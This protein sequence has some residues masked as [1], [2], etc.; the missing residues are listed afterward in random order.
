MVDIVFIH[1]LNSKIVDNEGEGDWPGLMHPKTRGVDAF[2]I[3]K[4]G[5]F[6]M[7]AFVGKNTCLR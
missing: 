4:R 2:A 5:Q 7:E 6:L 1:K 3:S